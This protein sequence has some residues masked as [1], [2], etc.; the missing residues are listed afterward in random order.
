MPSAT[1]SSPLSLHD[2]FRSLIS[3]LSELILH[4]L[5]TRTQRFKP[6]ASR[7]E[8]A[9]R[10]DNGFGEVLELGRINGPVEFNTRLGFAGWPAQ[11]DRKS[12]RLNSS[13]TVSSYAVCNLVFSSFPTRRL[14]ISHI[15]VERVDSARSGNPD[16]A[17]QTGRQPPRICPP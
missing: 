9:R 15:V 13:H 1:S 2:V 11:K 8:S 12:T 10:D 5:V 6:V 16:A 4:G 7:H 3:W 17:I 14:P